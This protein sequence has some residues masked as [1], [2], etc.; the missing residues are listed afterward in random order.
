[1]RE[2][3]GQ[4]R[5]K[6]ILENALKMDRLPHFFIFVGPNGVGKLSVAKELAMALNC[7]ESNPPCRVC[8]V[9]NSILNDNHPDVIYI[10]DESIGINQS[11]EVKEISLTS[12]IL[13]R[14]RIFIIENAENLTIPSANSLLKVLE[15]PPSS[16]I[17]IF[18]TKNLGNI[19]KTIVSRAI[20]VP[21]SPVRR[22]IIFSLLLEK[23]MKESDAIKISYLSQGDVE[24]AMEIAERGEYEVSLPPF[25][26]IESLDTSRTVLDSIS[27]WLRDAI[28]TIMG[29]Q[30]RFIIEKDQYQ[31]L[32]KGIYNIERLIDGFFFID[33]IKDLEESNGD[34]KFALELLYT[35]LE[36]K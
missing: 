26:Q 27:I 12:P 3:L 14:Y 21:F 11:R 16:T 20:I 22:D 25:S 6:V 2:I 5:A 31:N 35:E 10:K 29:A 13:G 9:C 30:E 36:V 7:P 28:I 1:M 8:N 33:N 34:W 32:W 19:L 17:F 23:G 24:R 18:T 4:K 15:E